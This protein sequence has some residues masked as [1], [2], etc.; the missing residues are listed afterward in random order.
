V[1]IS[2]RLAL[3][4]EGKTVPVV[5]RIL[6]HSLEALGVK[7]DVVGDLELALTEACTNVLDHAGGTEEYEVVATIDGAVC[8]IEVVDRGIGYD[9]TGAIDRGDEAEDGRGLFLMKAVADRVEVVRG[10]AKGTIV[11]IEKQLALRPDALLA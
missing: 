6:K 3:P 11:R 1:D 9:A 10:T 8:C 5:R 7:Q 2:L 4:R